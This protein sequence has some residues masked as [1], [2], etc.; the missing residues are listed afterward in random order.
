MLYKTRI[1]IPDNKIL[2]VRQ[3]QRQVAHKKRKKG[4]YF[5]ETV[6][7]AVPVVLLSVS[8]CYG[9]VS[10]FNKTFPGETVGKISSKKWY[11]IKKL[12]SETTK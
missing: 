9:L 3:E 10:I 6:K 4:T 1:K 2:T 5:R 8:G 7:Q 12:C 11:Q